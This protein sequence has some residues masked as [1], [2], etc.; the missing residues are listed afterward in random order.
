MHVAV[1]TWP[2]SCRGVDVPY[3][4]ASGAMHMMTV[5]WHRAVG[6][7]RTR[8][9]LLRLCFYGSNGLRSMYKGGEESLAAASDVSCST[10]CV[11][12]LAFL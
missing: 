5:Q 9:G 4:F 1:L 3:I 12:P 7:Q 8:R 11:A 10:A 6:C 2:P